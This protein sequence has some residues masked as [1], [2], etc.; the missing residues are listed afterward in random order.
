MGAGGERF[1]G[2][3][4][5]D[6]TLRDTKRK[7]REDELELPDFGGFLTSP[8]VL[9]SRNPLAYFSFTR[10]TSLSS[11]QIIG[12]RGGFSTA[13][14]VFGVEEFPRLLLFH[15][16]RF[17][18]ECSNYQ[19]SGGFLN[20]PRRFW[21]RGI[22]SSPTFSLVTL[23]HRVLRLPDF[24]GISRLP[25]PFLELRNPLVASFFTRQASSSSASKCRHLLAFLDIL[26]RFEDKEHGPRTFT[27]LPRLIPDHAN[28]TLNL[29][30]VASKARQRR[31]VS[32]N[33][34]KDVH[35][36]PASD[37]VNPT[38]FNR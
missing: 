23:P 29:F 8:N 21:G 35:S 17:P 28:P 31:S 15:S 14:T 4:G 27:L 32:L 5:R 9:G 7:S 19:T 11:V 18:V 24:G 10:H 30:D 38:A 3:E 20:C 16:S 33:M 37:T 2:N 22:P 34:F 12:L 36:Q 25:P 13:P 1:V 26:D 6:G